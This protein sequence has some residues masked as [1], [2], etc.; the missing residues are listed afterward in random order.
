MGKRH[1]FSAGVFRSAGIYGLVVLLPQYFLEEKLGRNFPPSLTHPEHFYGFLGVAVAWQFAFLFIARDVRRHRLVMLAAILEKLSFGIAALVLFS[2]G[3]TA[4]FVAGAGLVDLLFAVL[5]VLA[6]RACRGAEAQKRNLTPFPR[7][8]PQPSEPSRLKTDG[9]SLMPT[10][11]N[12][13]LRRTRPS[14]EVSIGRI[15]IA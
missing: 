5:F 6:F 12:H 2:Q 9:L 10:P 7:S 15:L 4:A 14:A 3:R 1:K 13:S 11:L 8:L